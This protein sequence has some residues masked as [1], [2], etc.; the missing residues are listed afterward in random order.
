MWC[1]VVGVFAQSAKRQLIER[2][3]AARERVTMGKHDP[4]AVPIGAGRCLQD[5]AMVLELMEADGACPLCW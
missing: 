5:E 4:L 1:L 2:R 3:T